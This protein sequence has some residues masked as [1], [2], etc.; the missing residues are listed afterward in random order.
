MPF[1]FCLVFLSINFPEDKKTQRRFVDMIKKIILTVL[2]IGSSVFILR[3]GFFAN[4]QSKDSK[5]SFVTTDIRLIDDQFDL[6]APDASR[7]RKSEAPSVRF[8]RLKEDYFDTAKG[9]LNDYLSKKD[10]FEG[11]GVSDREPSP[12][13]ITMRFSLSGNRLSLINSRTGIDMLRCAD[14]LE[15]SFVCF[16]GENTLPMPCL[17]DGRLISQIDITKQ[18]NGTMKR[19]SIRAGKKIFILFRNQHDTESEE[20]IVGEIGFFGLGS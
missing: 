8:K 13:N 15:C 2:A 7:K 1:A 10:D 9:F 12:V 16:Y 19:L 11:M 4:A 20:S 17:D 14:A 18:E 3:G 5:T 6:T